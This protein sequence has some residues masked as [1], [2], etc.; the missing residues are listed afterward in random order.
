MGARRVL[1]STGTP[2]TDATLDMIRTIL[3]I[4]AGWALF[5]VGTALLFAARQVDPY[6]D[7]STFGFKAA[8][9]ALAAVLGLAGGWLAAAVSRR[10]DLTAPIALALLLAS[11]AT[12]S[13]ALRPG[14]G[15][16][17]MQ[18][19]A[20]L[21]AAPMV[22]VGGWLRRRAVERRRAAGG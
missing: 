1:T 19:S 2:T 3:G 21:L 7:E 16:V 18:L 5:G 6:S 12:L 14:E 22:V 4:L 15:E 10:P 13:L 8:A 17:W 11:L 20:L 9:I